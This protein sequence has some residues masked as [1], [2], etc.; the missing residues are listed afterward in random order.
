MILE[1]MLLGQNDVRSNVIMTKS[2]YNRYNYDKNDVRS[3]VIR[4][5]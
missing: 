3:I 4:T 2:S 5:K 1:Q